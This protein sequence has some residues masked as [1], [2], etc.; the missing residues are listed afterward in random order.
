MRI[1]LITPGFSTDDSDWCIPV[2]QDLARHLARTHDLTVYTTCYPNEAR[3]YDVKGVAVRSFGDGR[4]GRRA[5][6]RRP[7][8]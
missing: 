3:Q 7:A 2:L 6:F 4:I 5:W 1:A 8:H